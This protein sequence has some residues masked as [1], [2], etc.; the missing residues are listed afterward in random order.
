MGSPS[1]SRFRSK[2]SEKA[3]VRDERKGMRRIDRLRVSTGKTC[4][5]KY[6]SSQAALSASI[7]PLPITSIP[8]SRSPL[9]KVRQT[10]CWLIVNS[11]AWVSIA[12]SCWA[13][14]RPSAENCSRR[15][16]AG[17]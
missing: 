12:A 13:G 6:W 4:W 16:I 11:S 17:P 9:R 2:I 5:R 8:A 15:A 1:E 7:S 14:V 3:L 10:C